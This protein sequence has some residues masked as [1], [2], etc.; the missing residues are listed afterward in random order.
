MSEP[1]IQ[2]HRTITFAA[3]A[4]CAAYSSYLVRNRLP[5]FHHV[6]AI[7]LHPETRTALVTLMG[8]G[9]VDQRTVD[10]ETLAA[11]LVFYCK[12]IRIPI[13]R[14][15]KRSVVMLED[16]I[17][18]KVETLVTMLPTGMV[19][20]PVPEPPPIDAPAPKA[21]AEARGMKW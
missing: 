2:D 1:L 16:R 17:V 10:L 15:V 14:K 4:V 20:R 19:G 3:P 7:S 13:P 8:G 18:L 5:G 11:A 9:V 12:E 6:A 21:S